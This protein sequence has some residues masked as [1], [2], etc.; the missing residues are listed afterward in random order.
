MAHECVHEMQL[1]QFRSAI[2]VWYRLTRNSIVRTDHTVRTLFRVD[3]AEREMSVRYI[4]WRCKRSAQVFSIAID[5]RFVKQETDNSRNL[6]PAYTNEN[7]I[8]EQKSET[9]REREYLI[10]P[11]PAR[12]YSPV[13]GQREAAQK[14]RL[15][16]RPVDIATTSRSWFVW[17]TSK[18][19]S[20]LSHM[21]CAIFFTSSVYRVKYLYIYTCY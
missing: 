7:L 5:A 19:P 10:T 8:N 12:N 14:A 21:M 18:S 6:D 16:N 20:P 3:C 15:R 9:T 13:C 11:S 17:Q 4:A 1:L 2:L